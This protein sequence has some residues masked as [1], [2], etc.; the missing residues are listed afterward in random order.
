MA[1]EELTKQFNA[2]GNALQYIIVLDGQFIGTWKR[3]LK[4]DA[5]HIHLNPLIKLTDDEIQAIAEAAEGY[6][7]FHNLP[8][9]LEM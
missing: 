7:E 1:G 6:G 9:I 5:V 4:K 3:T 2:M 8:V